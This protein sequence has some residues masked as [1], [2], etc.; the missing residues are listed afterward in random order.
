[1]GAVSIDVDGLYGVLAERG[2]EYG[3]AFQ[4][5][6]AAWR[7]GDEVF[8]EVALSEEE[9]ARGFGVH[10]A[11]LDASLHALG[12]D[13]M[14][15]GDDGPWVPFSWSGVS[16]HAVGASVARVRLVSVGVGVFSVT[17]ADETGA[18][19]AT[20]DSLGLRTVSLEQL[21]VAGSRSDSLYWL[22]WVEGVP[23]L[24][25]GCVL[26]DWVV[27][28]GGCG[29]L[30]D[31]SPGVRVLGDLASLQSE[32]EGGVAVPGVVL[33]ESAQVVEGSEGARAGVLEML[34]LLRGWLGDERLAGSRLVVVTRGAVAGAA[35]D[36]VRDL[37]G[38]AVWGLVRSAQSEN[39]GR[40]VLVDV[41]GESSSWEALAGALVCG[42]LSWWCVRGS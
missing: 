37:V 27:L 7:H 36:V 11:L 29:G 19:V 23:A 24:D 38:A 22:E 33:V 13:W 2:L 32:V 35:G 20:V 5:L 10:P 6:R 3:S 39:P 31:V 40:L 17:V 28:G 9:H 21:R 8:A 42:S 1:M 12:V 30:V 4:V 16:L 15:D 41:D 14:G 18:L 34:E 25:V 26:D